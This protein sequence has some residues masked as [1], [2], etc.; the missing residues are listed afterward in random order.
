MASIRATSQARGK[1]TGVADPFAHSKGS[2]N[3]NRKS[4]PRQFFVPQKVTFTV[5]FLV[6]LLAA[7]YAPIQDCDE[8]YNYWEPTHYL[9][10]HFGLQTWE[11][12]PEFSIRS[13]L[14]IFIHA[15]IGKLASFISSK[16]TFQFYAIRVVLAMAC[17]FSETS[18]F[19]AISR[20]LNPR[21]GV[22]FMI[23]MISSPGMF[24]ASV[25]YLPSSFSMCTAMLGTAAFMDWL[26]GLK[27][28]KGIMWFGIGAIIG[29]P[30]AAA[31]IAPLILED[32]YMAYRVKDRSQAAFRYANGML[33]CLVVLV[34]LS[35]H[36]IIII[37]IS[38][39][40]Q[41]LQASADT[42]FYRKVVI[43]PWRIVMYN[44]FSGPGRGPNIFGTEPWHFYLRNLSLNFNVWFLLAIVAAPLIE[45]DYRLRNRTSLQ[46]NHIRSL[47]FV[48]PFYLWLIIFSVQPHK[49]ERFMYPVYPFLCCN[50]AIALHTLLSYLGTSD[51]RKFLG[52]IPPGVKFAGITVFVLFTVGASILRTIGIVTAYQ[53]PLRVYKP[54]QHP[55]YSNSEDTV[56][57]G[58]EWYRFPSSYFLPN[59]MRARFV[60]SDFNGL[61]P[62]QFNEAKLGFSLFPGTWLEPPGMNDQNIEDPGKYIDLDHCTFLVDSYFSEAQQS[63]LEP[64]YVLD[65]ATW[66]TLECRS[67]LDTSR[68]GLLGR[69]FWIP[70]IKIIPSRLRRKWGRYC[71][72]RRRQRA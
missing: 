1:N 41:A 24:H 68:T 34:S 43:M 67:F 66:E 30:F 42:F 60:K 72:L 64:A 20:T 18:L 54:L 6:N 65:K 32:I 35:F 19:A 8:V 71:L 7:F 9:N 44:I 58:K 21:I 29:W 50:C 62:G 13:W 70:D 45:T 48:S 17:A 3:L 16:K 11:Y 5:F 57:L 52:K 61:L 23:A 36:S 49:E 53:A 22:M 55:K 40:T 38:D 4:H 69:I 33:R 27:T 26:G 56:C 10:H 37:T 39:L 14:Y 12:A 28:A 2:L 47:V 31:L 15:I 46:Q 63:S 59:S 51:R 25:A